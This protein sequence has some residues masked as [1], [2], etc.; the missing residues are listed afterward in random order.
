MPMCNPYGYYNDKSKS[1]NGAS[2]G[3]SDHLLGL[4]EGKG[5]ACR[6][7]DEITSFLMALEERINSE[8]KVLDLH[9][10][11]F[12]E[13][14]RHYGDSAGTY[15]Y[16][17]GEEADKNPLALRILEMLQKNRHPLIGEGQ[18][19]FKES[20]I[21]GLVTNSHDGSIDELLVVILRAGL[22]IVMETYVVDLNDP[23]L[24]ERVEI[25]TEALNIFSG[26][27]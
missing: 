25:Q 6:E 20:I 17:H 13:D 14:P 19:R 22:A 3:D 8:T 16:V 24:E 12:R 2:V 18:T 26:R 27:S 5:P 4:G 15:I 10:D 23:P 11:D 7:A 9:E 1:P 21:G